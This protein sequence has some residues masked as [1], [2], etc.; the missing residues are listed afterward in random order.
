MP[1]HLSVQWGEEFKRAYPNANILIGDRIDDKSRKEL[2]HAKY[3]NFDAIIMK[4]STFEN[5]S[6]MESFETQVLNEYKENLENTLR[7]K[8]QEELMERLRFRIG[9]FSEKVIENLRLF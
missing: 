8:R 1:N 6:V 5:M 4:H 3:G 2:Y 7:Q 9:N